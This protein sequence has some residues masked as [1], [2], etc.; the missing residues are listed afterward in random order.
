MR[1]SKFEIVSYESRFMEKPII[2]S[3]I[4]GKTTNWSSNFLANKTIP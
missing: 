4:L 1:N 3:R 2:Q